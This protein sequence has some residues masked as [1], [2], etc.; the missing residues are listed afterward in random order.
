MPRT[1]TLDFTDIDRVKREYF[2]SGTA[3]D[4]LVHLGINLRGLAQSEEAVYH[5]DMKQAMARGLPVAIHASQAPPSTVDA[6]DY[7]K[8]GWL[9]PGLLVCHY[10]PAPGLDAALLPRTKAPAAFGPASGFR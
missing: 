5:E 8:R 4:G 6:V 9:G 1:Q 7:E 10:I 3:F 2:G